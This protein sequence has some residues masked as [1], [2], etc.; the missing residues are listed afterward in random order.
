MLKGIDISNWNAQYLIQ[1][2]WYDLLTADFV[3]MKASEG[4]TYK[5]SC[6]DQYYNMVHGKTDGR[7][8]PDKLYGFYHYARPERYN[9]P[10]KEAQHFLSLVG[11]HAGNAIYALDVEGEALKMAPNYLEAWVFLWLEEIRIRTGV[12]SLVYCSA[13]VTNRFRL[14][15]E[16]DYGLWC[17]SWDKKPTKK[18][19]DP[20]KINAIWQNGTTNGHLDTDIFQGSAQAWKKYCKAWP[21]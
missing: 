12:K 11:H 13:S 17:A 6:L 19:I 15:A 16:N 3:I 8:D 9:D 10:K 14:A 18:M 2:D 20:W 21:H 4:L 1:R 7:P 5:D